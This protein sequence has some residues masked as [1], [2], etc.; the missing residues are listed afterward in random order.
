MTKL[1]TELSIAD[2]MER[3]HLEREAKLERFWANAASDLEFARTHIAELSQQLAAATEQL[4]A[5][6]A[7]IEKLEALVGE[8]V[9]RQAYAFTPAGA[10][11]IVSD[12]W[13]ARAKA[14]R[15]AVKGQE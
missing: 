13:I 10:H 14:L 3:K 5:K 6:D 7:K 12:D 4:A 1:P 11:A 2:D 8:A 15:S 9:N